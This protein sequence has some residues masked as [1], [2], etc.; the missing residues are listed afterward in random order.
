MNGGGP[1]TSPAAGGSTSAIMT[2]PTSLGRVAAA[3]LLAVP[4]VASLTA[5]APAPTVSGAKVAEFA[6][7]LASKKL[8]AFAMKDPGATT[9][10]KPRYLAALIVPKSQLLLVAATHTRFMDMEYYLHAKEFMKAYQDLNTNPSSIERFFVEDVMADGLVA[11]PK[12]NAP[13]DAV[14]IGTASHNFDGD[15][16]DPKR[17]NPNN[18][19]TQ[20]VYLKNFAEADQRYAA[21]LE[22]MIAQLKK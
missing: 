21:A 2:Q 22:L 17:R 13:A 5:Q 10:D 14:K 4:L 15:F 20:D 9:P 6:A 1:L 19:I 8:E 12:K 3:C 7:L 11:V 18:K 16:I